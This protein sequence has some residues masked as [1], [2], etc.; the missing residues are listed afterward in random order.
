MTG[1][2]QAHLGN[3]AA[4]GGS[5]T[6]D[7]ALKPSPYQGD[8][9]ASRLPAPTLNNLA[10]HRA[11]AGEPLVL[12]HGVGES[13]VGWQPVHQ[14]LSDDYD[15]IAFDFP[16]FGHSPALP[17]GVTPTAAAL[18]DAVERELDRLGVVQFHVAGYSLGARVALELATRGR[19]RSVIAIAP[20]GLGTP[21]ERLHQAAALLTG[22]TLATLLAPIAGPLTATGAGRSLFFAMERSRPWQLPAEDARQLLLD[23]AQAPGYLETVQATM[24]D[25]PTGLE[26]ITCPVLLMQGTADPLVSL[27]SPRFLAFVRH[28][29]MQWLPGLSHVPISD[30]P[31]LVASLMLRFLK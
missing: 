26:R 8:L 23:F 5:W 27:Q 6:G 9:I 20:D 7:G 31:R 3:G 11:G 1:H 24:V 15:V 16:G 10:H 30:D 19:T 21:L 29:Q 13:A 25:V 14:A 22:R 28:A 18:A 2:P 12:L 4:G 17:P